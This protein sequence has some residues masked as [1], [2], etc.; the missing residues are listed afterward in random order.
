MQYVGERP[1]NKLILLATPDEAEYVH[2]QDNG[3]DYAYKTGEYNLYKFH[4]DKDGNLTTELLH[5]GY[6][7]Y[8]E[9]KVVVL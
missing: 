8:D 4:T 7:L 1:Y 5:E 9:I 6:M 2:F 3:E